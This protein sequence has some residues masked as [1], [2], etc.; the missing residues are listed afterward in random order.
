MQRYPNLSGRTASPQWLAPILLVA[1]IGIF[2]ASYLSYMHYTSGM[3]AC[4][5]Q[6]GCDDV[7]SS[8]FSTIADVPLALF[9]VAFY[10]LVIISALLSAK[11]IQRAATLLKFAT[12]VGFCLSCYLVYL[13]LSV[14][15]AICE[16]CMVSFASSALLFAMT[17]FHRSQYSSMSFKPS[18]VW[19]FSK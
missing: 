16:Y 12:A 18:R 17:W 14:I 6:A 15:H 9:G 5:A 11:G 19:G 4:S 10:A 2:D 1:C 8:P 13:Q 7:L 3:V